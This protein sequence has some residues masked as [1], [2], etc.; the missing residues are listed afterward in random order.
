VV[1]NAA[2]EE[3]FAK[4]VFL[5]PDAQIILW[6]MQSTSNTTSL[7]PLLWFAAERDQ[8]TKQNE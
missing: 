1:R 4:I 3:N 6:Q 7:Q 2:T 8:Q 5:I